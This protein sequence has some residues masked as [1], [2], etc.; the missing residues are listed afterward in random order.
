[1]S[2]PMAL[3]NGVVF[4]G[5]GIGILVASTKGNRLVV[6][7]LGAVLVLHAVTQALLLTL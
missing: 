5:L 6:R 2:A 4:G 1:M 7:V 3:F